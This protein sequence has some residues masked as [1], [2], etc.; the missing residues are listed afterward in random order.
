[1]CTNESNISLVFS[2]FS[3][4][5]IINIVITVTHSIFSLD[6]Q[7]FPYNTSY[8]FLCF[9]FAL[10]CLSQLSHVNGAKKRPGPDPIGNKLDNKVSQLWD[11]TQQ[12]TIIQ[13]TSY[14]SF[15]LYL[16]TKP[17]NYSVVLMLTA[18]RAERSCQV[19]KEAKDEYKIVADSFR[20]SYGHR[21]A[22][23][24]KLLFFAMT[25]FDEGGGTIFEALHL[26][27][28]PMFIHYPPTGK[29]KAS[30]KF[31]LSRQGLHAEALA[32]WISDVTDVKVSWH[33][34]L[35]QY[36]AYSFYLCVY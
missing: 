36:L 5:P 16:R 22:T 3:N 21:D 26:K 34:S 14:D 17:R 15:Q 29:P 12:R 11:W 35:F 2:Q 28:A 33:I 19:C 32:Q 23:Q 6:T 25:D 13:F 10:L 27:T 30:D 20:F 4:F 24:D 18:L 8:S 7:M 9:C 1:M 31:D